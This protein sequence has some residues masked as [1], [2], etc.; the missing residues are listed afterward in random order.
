METRFQR[1]LLSGLLITACSAALAQTDAQDETQSVLDKIVTPDMERRHIEEDQLDTEDF[2][3]GA[4]YGFMSIEDF[5]SS[6]G[7]GARAA[8]HITEDFFLEGNY[9]KHTAGESTL[10]IGGGLPALTDAQREYTYYDLNLGYNLF[11]G[12]VYISDSL[13]FNS[14]FYIVAGAGNTTFAETEYFTY[15]FGAGYKVYFTDYLNFNIDLRDHVFERELL[16]FNKK[17][18]NNLSANMGINFFF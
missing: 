7:W 11:P 2:E 15:S 13:A 3:L 18:V 6:W 8:Y 4:Y 9:G 14:T 12:E 17:W 16:G 5:G 1:L 10:E